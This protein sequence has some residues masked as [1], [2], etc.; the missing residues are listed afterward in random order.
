[1]VNPYDHILFGF[2]L[3]DD[4]SSLNTSLSQ[5]LGVWLSTMSPPLL[6]STRKTNN[7]IEMLLPKLELNMVWRRLTCFIIWKLR[8][9]L[10]FLTKNKNTYCAVCC[11]FIPRMPTWDALLWHLGVYIHSNRVLGHGQ[12]KANYCL[13]C[14]CWICICSSVFLCLFS[15]GSVL[16]LVLVLMFIPI[17]WL[18]NSMVEWAWGSNC[19]IRNCFLPEVWHTKF[20]KI[21]FPIREKQSS[22]RK[23]TSSYD[24]QQIYCDIKNYALEAASLVALVDVE[25]GDS[26]CTIQVWWVWTVVAMISSRK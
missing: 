19:C 23:H 7:R 16:G 1:M 9:M 26:K 4:A 21:Y 2:N 14:H 22:V 25:W 8:L 17:I 24:A 12:D 13:S 3:P 15:F 20:K 11:C 5:I 6:C 18:T 10:L